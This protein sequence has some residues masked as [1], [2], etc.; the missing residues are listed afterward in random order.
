MPSAAEFIRVKIDAALRA[1]ALAEAPVRQMRRTRASPADAY[2]GVLGELAWAVWRYGD[3]AQFDTL[4]T[5]GQVDD[6]LD[7][8]EIKTSKTRVD[9]RSHLMVREDYAQKRRAAF[10]V[11]ALVPFA[12]ADGAETDVF[13]C[14]WATH[15]ELMAH[16]PVERVSR[17]TGK[18]QGY[19]CYEIVCTDLHAMKELKTRDGRRKTV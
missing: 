15:D 10:Y 3:A 18:P 5:K 16:P 7:G 17:H 19:K 12:Q 13:L 6:A 4:H 8:A 11:L 14:G 2:L 9:A 1:R